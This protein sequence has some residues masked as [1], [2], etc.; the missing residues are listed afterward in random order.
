MKNEVS[1]PFPRYRAFVTCRRQYYYQYYGKWPG[2]EMGA[3]EEVRLCYRLSKIQSLVM[4]AGSVVHAAIEA[5]LKQV[6]AGHG[7]PT[8]AEMQKQA[9]GRLNDAW[10]E[11]ETKRWRSSPSQYTNLLEHY[12]GREVPREE[13]R[14]IKQR[15]LESLAHWHGSEALARILACGAEDWKPIEKLQTFVVDGVP[16][17]VKFDFAGDFDGRLEIWDWKTGGKDE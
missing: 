2:W 16:A 8:L 4:L 15:V 3:P 6:Q 1:W 13:R 11:S 9:V 10:I 17:V 12:Y 7:L 5:A 14:R